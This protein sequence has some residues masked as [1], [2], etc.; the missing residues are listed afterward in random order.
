[1]SEGG[2]SREKRPFPV[3]AMS[4]SRCIGVVSRNRIT[5][6]TVERVVAECTKNSMRRNNVWIKQ[7]KLV[8]IATSLELSQPNFTAIIYARNATHFAKISRIIFWN[9]WARTNGKNRKHFQFRPRSLNGAIRQ[10]TY[11]SLFDFQRTKQLLTYL[12]PF[13]RSGVT[14]YSQ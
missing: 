13:Q 14:K 2:M 11:D 7:T 1:M 8:A 4:V 12:M 5:P 9:N 6:T 10:I 3:G